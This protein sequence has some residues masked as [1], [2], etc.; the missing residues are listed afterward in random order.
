KGTAVLRHGP[1][2]RI[3]HA[4]LDF[5]LNL[6]R[7]LHARSDETDEVRDYLVSNPASVAPHAGGVERDAPVEALRFRQTWGRNVCSSSYATAVC[8]ELPY[9]S[10]A[11]R[12]AGIST[13]RWRCLGS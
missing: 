12:L 13:C 6:Q 7:H 3:R 4:G 5:S 11:V 8:T 1:H 10:S 2:D 9:S